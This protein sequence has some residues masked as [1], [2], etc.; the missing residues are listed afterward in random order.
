VYWP[1][2]GQV[3]ATELVVRRLLPMARAGL[4]AWGVQPEERDR[5]LDIIE[6]RCIVGQNGASWFANRFAARVDDTD[7]DRLEALRGTLN[8]YRKHMHTNEP[9][10]TWD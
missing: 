2:L 6:Q 7:G 4:D 9:V 3:P 5:L 1:G 8:D 10:H